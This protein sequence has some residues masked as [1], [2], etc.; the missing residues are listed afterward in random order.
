MSTDDQLRREVDLLGRMF[1]DVVRRFEGEEA[2]NL[3][4]EVRRLARQFA[5]GD[6]NA[7]DQLGGL[8]HGLS[9]EQ[10]R[11]VVRA[12][13]TFLELANLAEDRQRVRT[14]RRRER[15]SYPAPHKESI[16]EVIDTLHRRDFSAAALEDLL[17]RIDVELVFTAHPTEAKRKSLRSKLRA[18]RRI[19]N[20]LDSD[21]LLPSEAK[22]LDTQL[23]GELIKLW[24]TDLIRPSRP[25][26]ELEVNRGLSFQPVLWAT[27]PKVLNELRESVATSYPGNDVEIPP[28]LRFGSWMGGDRDGHP[29]VTPEITAQTCQW[30][31]KAALD[32][33]LENRRVLADS[34]SI[35]RRQSP[36]CQKIE[37]EIESA[38]RKWSP[39][40]QALEGHGVQ[41]SYR[42]WLRIIRWRLEQTAAVELT[43]PMPDGH[44]GSPAELAADVEL[45]RQVLLEDGNTEVATSE[46]QAWIDQISVFGFHTARLDVRQHAGVYREVMEEIWK[47]NGLMSNAGSPSESERQDL[48]SSRLDPRNAKLPDVPSARMT[49][50]LELFRTLRR[51]ARRYGMS[52]LG[53]H[54]VSMTREPSDLLTVLWFWKWSMATDGGDAADAELRLP[55]VP[56]FETISDLERAG[57][58][59]ATLLDN[60]AYREWLDAQGDRQIVMIGYS[61]STKDG[62]YLAACWN[63]QRVQSDLHAVAEARGVKLTFFHGRG[64]SLGRGGGPAARAIL[65]LPTPAFD[66]S[67]RLTEQGEILA[68]RYDDPHVAFRHLEQVLWSVLVACTKG[69]AATPVAWG[70]QMDAFAS[71]SFE[72]YR[73]LIDHPSF[74]RFFRTVTPI[75][76]I[77]GLQIAS[78]PARRA[79]SDRIEDLRAIPWV[80]AWTQCRC[81]IPAW[82]GLGSAIAEALEAAP[83]KLPEIR[84]MYHDWPFF[85]ATIDNAVLAV[86]KSNLP[87]FRRYAE[88]AGD[89]LGC[90]DIESM[91]ETEWRLTDEVLRK[92]TDC[93]E[94][95]DDVPWLKRSIAFRNGYVDPLNLIQVELQARARATEDAATEPDL[96][97]VRQLA[98]KGVA[99][100]MRTTG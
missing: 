4:E 31:R 6:A 48:L 12:F 85:R 99:A 32:S 100:G 9:L 37:D 67:L 24:Q 69:A 21:Q 57:D 64:G 27:V 96:A 34:L 39:L 1:G 18:I 68:E 23:R 75:T 61:D 15:E 62:G 8:L 14:L 41:E 95:L 38:C 33:H 56:L 90:R 86:A 55:I 10:L 16:E 58:I 43:G 2:F 42:R 26:V 60:S 46:V 30:L 28:V 76:D 88:L 36:A 71:S 47:A 87:V 77:E 13:S 54:V 72:A 78:R 22:Q 94:L 3:V 97:H 40:V 89:D 82:Y 70:K 92:I 44:Y 84:R 29:F 17:R 79:A 50:T 66:G 20:E 49:E 7:A 98:V 83:D 19:M 80:F 74:G 73:R 35:S 91:I 93:S 11:T 5:S 59:L 53:G 45:I 63:L 51:I 65:S 25:T 52:A 81:L